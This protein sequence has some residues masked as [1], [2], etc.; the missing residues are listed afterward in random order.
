MGFKI[1]ESRVVDGPY[2][3]YPGERATA[4]VSEEAIAAAVARGQKTLVVTQWTIEPMPGVKAWCLR[5][6]WRVFG[7]WLHRRPS[8]RRGS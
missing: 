3:L 6:G 2:R 4:H 5:M 7:R 1:G 8:G